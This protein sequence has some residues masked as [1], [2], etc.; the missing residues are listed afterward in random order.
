MAKGSPGAK[1]TMKNVTVASAQS[2]GM[3]S[4]IRRTM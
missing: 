4:R 1:R 3:E 2:S